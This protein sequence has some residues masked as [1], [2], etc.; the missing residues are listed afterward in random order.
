MRD[1]IKTTNEKI[2]ETETHNPEYREK[3]KEKY[4]KARKD[5]GLDDSKDEDSF[6]KYLGVDLLTDEDLL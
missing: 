4:M 2:A 6:L 3:Y 1:L 5:A